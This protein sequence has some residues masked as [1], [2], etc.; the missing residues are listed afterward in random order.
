MKLTL[1]GF[2]EMSTLAAAR[3]HAV[4]VRRVAV[5][6]RAQTEE[7]SRLRSQI[8]LGAAERA[9]IVRA[10]DEL[11]RLRRGAG[12]AGAGDAASRAGTSV[13]GAQAVHAIAVGVS[14]GVML[15]YKHLVVEPRDADEAAR[16]ARSERPA[17]AARAPSSFEPELDPAS[18]GVNI[19]PTAAAALDA[20]HGAAGDMAGAAERAAREVVQQWAATAG[21][22]L[23][24]PPPPLARGLRW[25]FFLSHRQANSGDQC[26]ALSRDLEA[27]GFRVWF[28]QQPGLD[29]TEV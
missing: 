23:P 18:P 25:H 26:M 4:K 20:A 16:A 9:R 14:L 19:D 12:G 1:F 24:P 11:A 29:V 6:M 13:G 28:D 15:A 17:A 21:V 3:A 10:A 5:R 27:K 22:A 2:H 7:I 8:S